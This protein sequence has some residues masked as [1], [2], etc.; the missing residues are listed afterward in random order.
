MVIS[1]Y[2]KEE[3]YGRVRADVVGFDGT[4]QIRYYDQSG[5]CYRTEDF[6]GK[7][8]QEV[9]NIAEDWALGV[10]TLNG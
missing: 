10:K 9:E 2:F 5:V 6:R 4:Y 8:L 1:S 7:G 3:T